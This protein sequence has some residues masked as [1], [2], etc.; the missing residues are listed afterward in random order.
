MLIVACDEDMPSVDDPANIDTLEMPIDTISMDTLS[1][2]IDSIL[3]DITDVSFSGDDNSYTF[4]ATI[5]SPDV[6]CDQYANWWEIVSLDGELIYRRILNHSHVDEQPFTRS[7]GPIEIVA[8]E[9]VYVRAWM[10]PTGYGGK[11]FKGSINSGFTAYN[12]PLDF[13]LALGNQEPLPDFCLY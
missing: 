9:E 12:L 8:D 5:L 2:S 13:A 6:D 11:V 10:H 7:G 4:S 3:A 1:N